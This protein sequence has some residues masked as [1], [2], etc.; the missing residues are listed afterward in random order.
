VRAADHHHPD[1]EDHHG[2]HD[3]RVHDESRARLELRQEQIDGEM[4]S[5]AHHVGGAQ[6]ADP[7]QHEPREFIGKAARIAQNEPR[8]HLP[9]HVERD[10]RHEDDHHPGKNAVEGYFESNE[11]HSIARTR[12]MR[13]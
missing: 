10:R 5:L 9:Q 3:D 13:S 4:P 1:R 12:S 11:T 8:E 2:R 6:Q 7:D